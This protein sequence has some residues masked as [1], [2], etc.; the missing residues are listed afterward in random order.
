MAPAV[1]DEAWR[2]SA[3][4]S[5]AK[6]CARGELPHVRVLKVIRIPAQALCDSGILTV[7]GSE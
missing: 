5:G 3:K 1:N 7:R 4:A 2:G 6:L